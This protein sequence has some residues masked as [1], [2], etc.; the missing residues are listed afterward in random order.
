MRKY[1]DGY[2]FYNSY[3]FINNKNENEIKISFYYVEVLKFI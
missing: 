3:C 2:F 1:I